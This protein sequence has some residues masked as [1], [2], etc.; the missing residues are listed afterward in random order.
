MSAVSGKVLQK[1][2][3]SLID[4]AALDVEE[5]V[6]DKIEVGTISISVKGQSE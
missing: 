3:L 5:L 1:K 4:P 2:L 6:A